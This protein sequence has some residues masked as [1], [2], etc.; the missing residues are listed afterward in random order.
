MLGG[1]NMDLALAALVRKKLETDGKTLDAFQASTLVHACR[2]AKEKLL[3]EGAPKQVPVVVSSRGSKLVAGALR[4]ELTRAE[5][6]S[7]LV[8][9]FFPKVDASARPVNRARA[10]LTE[11]GLP[12]AQDAAITRHLSAFLTRQIASTTEL[13]GFVQSP[14]ATF[15]HPTAVLF[16]G[17][18]LKSTVLRDRVMETLN[19]WLGKEGAPR[20]RLLSGADLDLAVARGAA[21]Y[22]Y[23]RRGKGVRIRGGT[24]KSYYVGVESAVPAVPGLDPPVSALCVAPFGME[25][26]TE[27][28]PAPQELGLVVGEPVRFRFFE[29]ATRRDDKPGTMVERFGDE[30]RELSEIEATMPTV[31]RTEGGVVPVRLSAVVT[32]VGTLRL[33]AQPRSGPE[34]WKVELDVRGK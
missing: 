23:V 26:G 27:A 13:E 31:G 16:N 2:V 12:Y 3:S 21:Y 4:A 15:L 17:G 29:S 28:P 10:A 6:E 24:A 11:L 34:R 9:G 18:V 20:A 33:E 22:A 25:E 32:E 19:G 5:V 8:D 1:D 30:L 14:G 7:V